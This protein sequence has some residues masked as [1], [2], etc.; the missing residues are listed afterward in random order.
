MRTQLRTAAMGI[1]LLAAGCWGASKPLPKTY[2]V[3]GQV[4]RADGAPLAE[5]LV[6]FTP[7]NN[8]AGVSTSGVTGADGKFRLSTIVGSMKVDGATEGNHSV[9]VIPPMGQAQQSSPGPPP[10]PITLARPYTVKP[11][12][13]NNFAITLPK[14]P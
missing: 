4:L 5:A 1:L 9:T 10:E 6:Q 14:G 8:P 13:D 3:T 7:A 12:G 2:P 11:D